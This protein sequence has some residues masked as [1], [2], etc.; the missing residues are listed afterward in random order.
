MISG[1]LFQSLADISL[2]TTITDQIFKQNQSMPQNLKCMHEI[3]ISEISHYKRIFVYTYSI[4]DFFDK[5]YNHLAEDTI[6]I[7]HNS[8]DGISSKFLPYL[9]GP[10]IYKWY[11]QNMETLHP[12][13]HSIPI[14]LA[15]SQ[16]PHGNQSLIK[17]IRDKN[18]PK[19]YLVYKN[20]DIGTNYNERVICNNITLENNIPLSSPQ[21]IDKY[22]ETLARSMFVI[23]P[24]GNGIDCHRIW[25][26]LYLRTV[27][28]VKYNE[29]FSRFVDLPILFVNSWDEVTVPYLRE[30]ISEYKNYD[31]DTIEELEIKYWEKKICME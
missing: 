15:N 26:A 13:L 27:P 6:L 22:W 20:F 16:W 29:A 25:E 4:Q 14:G 9:E 1:E 5:F 30:K 7:T 2:T 19:E 21:T 23:S 24:P 31:W 3:D 12:K 8:D 10:K 11:C 18:L 28:I 17:T